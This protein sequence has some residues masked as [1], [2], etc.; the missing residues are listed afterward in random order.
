VGSPS[1]SKCEGA[2]N[3]FP[4]TESKLELAFQLVSAPCGAGISD[5][6][7]I[8]DKIESTECIDVCVKGSGIDLVCPGDAWCD[9]NQ[10][11]PPAAGKAYVYYS[12][13]HKVGKLEGILA[14]DADLHM[15]QSKIFQLPISMEE[16]SSFNGFALVLR[17]NRQTRDD[18][19]DQNTNPPESGAAYIPQ[20]LAVSP[21]GKIEIWGNAGVH[22]T[23]PVDAPID[24]L[25]PFA[26]G[27]VCT[28]GIKIGN[29]PELNGRNACATPQQA[30]VYA[31]IFDKLDEQQNKV[32]QGQIFDALRRSAWKNG[33]GENCRPT[34][35]MLTPYPHSWGKAHPGGKFFLNPD[36][37]VKFDP[38][39]DPFAGTDGSVHIHGVGAHEYFHMLQHRWL[40]DNSSSKPHIEFLIEEHAESIVFHSCLSLNSADPEQCISGIKLRPQDGFGLRP[41]KDYEKVPSLNA[42]FTD[43]AGGAFQM[44]VHEQF[45]YPLGDPNSPH[46]N[47]IP[48]TRERPISAG[49]LPLRTA[50]RK[51][52]EGMDMLG[53]LYSTFDQ[54]QPGESTEKLM[55]QC[56]QQNLGRS[57]SSLVADFHT[58]LF[59]KDYNVAE[60]PG[61]TSSAARW[62]FEWDGDGDSNDPA[63][64]SKPYLPPNP[65]ATAFPS[66][67]FHATRVLDSYNCT[68]TG[69][70]PVLPPPAVPS[71]L[72]LPFGGVIS[73]VYA[74]TSA[75]G[76]AAWS[77]KPEPGWIG[78]SVPFQASGYGAAP[79][80][81]AFAIQSSTTPAGKK[82]LSPR[83]VCGNAP[84]YFCA[85]S[86]SGG[87][88]AWNVAAAVPVDANTDEILVIA[89]AL[90]QPTQTNW[91]IGNGVPRVELVSPTSSQHNFIGHPSSGTFPVFA[92]AI[93]LGPDQSGLPIQPGSVVELE[94]P[95]CANAAGPGGC[96]LA[97]N[98]LTVVP[99]SGG[100]FLVLAYLPPT[101]YPSAF[102]IGAA[103]GH[104]DLDLRV[105]VDGI[106]SDVQTSSLRTS[107]LP[108]VRVNS[109]VIDNSGSMAGAKLEGAKI[110]AKAIVGSMVPAAGAAQSHWLNLV[111]FSDDASTLPLSAAPE[112]Y[113]FLQVSAATKAQAEQAIDAIQPLNFTSIGDGMFEAQS[114]M[115][116]K[117]QPGLVASPPAVDSFH[118]HVL[119]DGLNNRPAEPKQYYTGQ[120]IPTK[121][122]NGDWCSTTLS[123]HHRKGQGLFVPSVSTIAFGQD[124]DSEVLLDVA[125]VTGG[126]YNYAPDGVVTT[127]QAMAFLSQSMLMGQNDSDGTQRV[128]AATLPGDADQ[129]F[130]VESGATELRIVIAAENIPLDVG[131]L[132]YLFLINDQGMV[133]IQPSETR[134][135]RSLVLKVTAPPPGLWRLRLDIPQHEVFTEA[136][137][138]SPTRLL[139]FA[140]AGRVTTSDVDN[141]ILK[142]KTSSG[143]VEL[144][145]TVFTPSGALPLC[146]VQANILSPLGHFSTHVLLDNGKSSDGAASD[147]VFGKTLTLP[148]VP[149]TYLAYFAAVCADASQ[150]FVWR[151]ASRAFLFEFG[152]D[153]DGDGMP[154]AWEITHALNPKDPS[155]ASQD[156]D[157][158]GLSNL[159]EFLAGTNPQLADTD[160]S[161]EADG[162]EV[163][164]GKDPL[165]PGD[166]EVE[167]LVSKFIFGSAKAAILLGG[168]FDLSEIDAQLTLASVTQPPPSPSPPPRTLLTKM[169]PGLYTVPLE[170]GQTHCLQVRRKKG[171]AYG[172]WSQ[173]H[174]QTA[175]ADT[176]PPRVLV[177]KPGQRH[178]RWLTVDAQIFDEVPH[179]LDEA[180]V[181]SL[182][183]ASLGPIEVRVGNSPDFSGA[184][185]QSLTGSPLRL[186][187]SRA[188]RQ[189]RRLWL[190]ARDGAGNL[191]NPEPIQIPSRAEMLVDRAISLEED[192][193]EEVVGKKIR[194]KIR[195][196]LPRLKRAV[197]EVRKLPGGEAIQVYVDTLVNRIVDLKTRAQER[198]KKKDLAGARALLEQALVLEHELALSLDRFGESEPLRDRAFSEDGEEE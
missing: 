7:C 196:S 21:D 177:H 71:R 52:D 83:P 30:G 40:V 126:T 62:R 132:A 61:D 76:A 58:A 171:S 63:E 49:S 50:T 80:F 55:D 152:K 99:L 108:E 56:F 185:W 122:E 37:Q 138:T 4:L 70:P 2:G 81:R 51:T 141:P 131:G 86:A 133:Q 31:N 97:G 121:D 168:D 96:K 78:S 178:G 143:N 60:I 124:A 183:L 123:W 82:K 193:I 107:V 115:A 191:S 92:T 142:H 32:V 113:G 139:A 116:C 170:P 17:V 127:A 59:L 155:D 22:N 192:A 161:G 77:V 74:A 38:L 140:E 130:F 75:Y 85:T 136:A 129:Y 134:N 57:L 154:D 94:V 146:N 89:S 110:A 88:G 173:P 13:K 69:C 189:A 103:G 128:F 181:A 163:S 66:K 3:D 65:D 26:L 34:R 164:G 25:A 98:N 176:I 42:V 9:P 91:A 166:D 106:A 28:K 137:V 151:Q 159:E 111:T 68:S 144:R 112:D 120:N 10:P 46:P 184:T 48:S 125:R 19:L 11:N 6:Q 102:A 79:R 172:P 119:S 147:G 158:D 109:L 15:E 64:D 44:Y 100:T 87:P 27:D 135:N 45:A 149:G 41:L 157:N 194:K 188:Q 190:Q 165:S 180:V 5:A 35:F 118:M 117:F 18:N 101:F 72:M 16:A 1:N 29:G 150:Q 23:N 43:Y 179:A 156:L 12:K 105:L 169:K 175:R 47:G 95:G 36:G 160:G 39:A 20:R 114:N 174:C 53:L 84:D 186:R 8:K 148:A 167:P 162:S 182:G 198:E 104:I 33:G 187:V 14:K 73:G 54:A 197:Q 24:P 67:H 145:A 195:Q 153:S 93:Y 90:N